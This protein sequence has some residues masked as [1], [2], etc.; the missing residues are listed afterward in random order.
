M[1]RAFFGK[2]LDDRAG[3]FVMIRALARAARVDCD[4]YLIG[5]V[6]E[7][8]GLRGAGPA[9]FAAAPDILLALEGTF[10][11]DVP[12]LS[13]PANMAPHRPGPG[14]RRYGST[15]RA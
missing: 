8:Y 11:L 6:Q 15:I 10:A 14:A 1:R 3:V 5:S 13:L 12:G 7:E 2:A 9:V 4:L